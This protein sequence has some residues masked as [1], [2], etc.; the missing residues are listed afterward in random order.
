M[1]R[2]LRLLRLRLRLSGGG[3]GEGEV[4]RRVVAAQVGPSE[5]SKKFVAGFSR[6]VKGQAQGSE[7]GGFKLWVKLDLTRTAPHRVL[8]RL[9]LRGGLGVAVQLA[10][11]RQILKP[12]LMFKGTGLKPGAFQLWLRGSRRVQPPPRRRR[13][14]GARE[15]ACQWQP[16]R[17]GASC[18]FERHILKPRI[19]IQR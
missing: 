16:R 3:G 4:A 10:F 14:A 18:E 11:E 9:V 19:D 5:I 13:R 1:R 15:P 17:S 2:L 12:G 8:R 6:W 7:P